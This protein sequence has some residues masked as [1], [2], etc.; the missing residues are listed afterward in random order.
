MRTG[1]THC[2]SVTPYLHL[3]MTPTNIIF[4]K[5]TKEQ[6]KR[7]EVALGEAVTSE[8]ANAGKTLHMHINRLKKEQIRDPTSVIRLSFSLTFR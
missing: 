6:N 7:V 8:Q 5:K 2:D 3:I 1:E 4:S